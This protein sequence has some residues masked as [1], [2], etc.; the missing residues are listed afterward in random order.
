M[1]LIWS[2]AGSDVLFL[3]AG[4]GEE[5]VQRG[6]MKVSEKAGG[7]GGCCTPTHTHR[8]KKGPS[9]RLFWGGLRAYFRPLNLRSIFQGQKVLGQRVGKQ[10]EIF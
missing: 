10:P 3:R 8:S 6:L 2:P 7:T 9:K 5:K 1:M 4:G